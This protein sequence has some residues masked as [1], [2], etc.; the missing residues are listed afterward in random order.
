MQDE[1]KMTNDMLNQLKGGASNNIFGSVAVSNDG[2]YCTEF[3]T[4]KCNDKGIGTHEGTTK[5]T[6]TP[7]DVLTS[8]KP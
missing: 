6:I 8:S 1:F 3:C 7:G 4:T 2:T 5:G